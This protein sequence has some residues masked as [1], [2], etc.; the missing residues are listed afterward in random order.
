MIVKHVVIIHVVSVIRSTCSLQVPACVLEVLRAAVGDQGF[1][2][3]PCLLDSG[4][5]DLCALRISAVFEK[6]PQWLWRIEPTKT[7]F[8]MVKV[9]TLDTH[10]G[11]DS[12][13]YKS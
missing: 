12:T 10:C 5:R 1:R 11:C 4:E 7:F 6:D 3:D 8:W 13:R 9:S 2:R